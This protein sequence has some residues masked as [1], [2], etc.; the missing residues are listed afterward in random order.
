MNFITQVKEL[1]WLFSSYFWQFKNGC[2]SVHIEKKIMVKQ[3]GRR[4]IKLELK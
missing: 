2:W 4:E 3:R 1:W